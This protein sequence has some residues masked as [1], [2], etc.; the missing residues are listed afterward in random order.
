MIRFLLPVTLAVVLMTGS[1]E[2]EEKQVGGFL[3]GNDLL[4]WCS[5]AITA[6]CRAYDM[7]ISDAMGSAGSL[8]GFR[9]CQP[10]Q[11]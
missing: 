4:T 5:E 8:A 2:A 10:R 3:S 6:K 1:I 11:A 7:G 9:A